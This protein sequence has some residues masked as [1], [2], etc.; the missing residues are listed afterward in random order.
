MSKRVFVNGKIFTVNKNKPWAEALVIEDN[1]I[2]YVGDN[3]GAKKYLSSGVIEEDLKGKLVTPGLI[4]GHI[5]AL[6]AVLV[7]CVIVLNA[8][9]DLETI[10]KTC[11]DYISKHPDLP[12]YLGMGWNDGMFGEIGPNKKVLDE[13]C[14]DKPLALFSASGHCGWC[15]S[16]ALEGA[17][18]DKN[19]KDP[20]RSAGH[21]FMRDE[22]N[23]PTGYVK[24][25]VC[26]NIIL[27]SANFTPLEMLGEEAVRLGKYCASIGLTSVFDCGNYDFFEHIVN[28][29]LMKEIDNVDC[30]VRVDLCG[31]IAN[32]TNI[33]V[34]Y[35]EAKKLHSKYM[36]DM[37]RC[38]F[39][40][41]LN[42][43]TVENF[44]AAIPNAYPGADKVKP[45]LS[46]DELVYWGDKAAKAGLDLNVH[47]IGS[48]T[49]HELLEA[50]GELRKMGHKDMRIICSHS[51]YVFPE[52]LELFG[53]YD[54]I[55]NSTG[56]WFAACSESDEKLI[57]SLTQAKAYPMKSILTSGSKI[58]LSSDYPTD[59]HALLPIPNMEVAITRQELGDK[60]GFIHDEKERLTL[61]EVIEAYTLSN[62]YEMR[63]ED[64]IGS[65]EVGKY[66]DIVIFDKNLFELDPHEIHTAKIYETIM[67]GITRYKAE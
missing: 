18:I 43:G 66:A 9:M 33:N 58:S 25:T 38:T 12:A 48:V 27:S 62:A 49:I 8:S 39:L 14:K 6:M 42:D 46:K 26:T 60:N 31:V 17:H 64:K 55:G 32:N 15:N 37:F 3:E 50:A 28:D 57:E 40:K 51:A 2:I 61:E 47:A 65:L 67:N 59:A 45:T 52:D 4:D 36:S 16:K 5:H 41:I 10:C 23:E 35:E 53:K 44:S 54:V 1:K 22:N 7:R 29:D 30:P 63:M 34:A 19:F 11:K 24:E 21:F 20:D 13:I 56:L